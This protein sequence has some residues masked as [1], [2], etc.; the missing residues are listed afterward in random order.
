MFVGELKARNYRLL[1][2]FAVEFAAPITVLIGPNNAGKS[3]VV[4][5]L[6]LLK[7][8]LSGAAVNGFLS[9]RRGFERVVT[10]HDTSRVIEL[11]LSG[12]DDNRNVWSYAISL[13]RQ[14]LLS[15]S[16]TGEG[17]VFKG[18]L[19][20]GPTWT[21]LIGDGVT[22]QALGSRGGN[23][24]DFGTL[25]G[26][27]SEPQPIATHVGGLWHV[28]PFRA[29]EP[30]YQVGAKTQVAATGVDLAQALH[31]NYSNDRERFDTFE[32]MVQ[33]VLP[34][35]ELIETPI[36]EGSQA[37]VRIRFR[38]DPGK[39]DLWQ[40]SSGVKD[41][42][43]LLA[44]IHFSERGQLV[45][46]EEP[47]NHLHP[48]SQK[49]L[50]AVFKSSAASD[51]KQ[52]I[53]TTHSETILGQFAP[54]D[55]VYVGKREA[56]AQAQPLI[57]ADLFQVWQDLGIDR[58]VLLQLLGRKKQVVVIVEGRVDYQVL[59]ALWDEYDLRDKVLPAV[60]AGGGSQ[61]IVESAASLR[62]SLARFR[63]PSTVFVLLDRDGERDEKMARLK[64]NG[65]S[66]ADSHVW[67][68]KEIESY[69][70]LPEALSAI[71][72]VPSNE[73]RKAIERTHGGGKERLVGVLKEL[74]IEG[75]PAHV[76]VT[77]ALARNPGEVPQELREVL[78]KISRLLA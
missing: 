44:A 74:H 23:P 68:E 26:G 9:S 18:E 73:A 64:A 57:K 46:I 31:F 41:A 67:T 6:L 49:A 52:F 12:L 36:T 32:E 78:E 47:E 65:F 37:T 16:A 54:E 75:T 29:V 48:A 2:D 58:S 35:V 13:N 62:D 50:S 60:A 59:D 27:P 34:E 43:I 28:E 15:E 22:M 14:G 66:D 10:A 21:T 33:L 24:M 19:G 72:G 40:L 7:E 4:D 76:I 1:E 55:V 20:S 61:E 77:N 53:L 69:A 5:A 70:L 38:D 17:W 25:Y 56:R 51:D 30:Q 11:E 3:N 45:V 39:Y 63:L 8:A 71:A 42:M